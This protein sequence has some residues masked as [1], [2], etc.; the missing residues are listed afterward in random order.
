[1]LEVEREI[2][3]A[4]SPDAVWAVIG[5][6]GT[7]AEW[8]PACSASSAETVGG[9][10]HRTVI[11]GDGGRLVEKLEGQDNA[12]R[13]YSYSVIDGPLPVQNYLSVLS[14]EANGDGSLV[15]WTGKFDAKDAS[16]DR[17]KGVIGGIYDMG[18][19]ALQKRFP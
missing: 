12:A 11:V 5:D 8:H 2:E 14:V 4:G 9:D 1:M 7:I 3:L 16:D 19:A 15:R 17:A 10:V 13:A 18:L 6:F